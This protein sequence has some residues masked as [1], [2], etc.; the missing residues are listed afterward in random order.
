MTLVRPCLQEVYVAGIQTVSIYLLKP[1]IKSA[2]AAL[3]SE[4]NELREHAVS[5]GETTGTLFV[6]EGQ[7]G[8]PDWVRFLSGVTE[9]ELTDRTRSIKALLMLEAAGRW[10]AIT[11]G[12]ARHLLKPDSYE[13][14]F[15]L[16]CA[17]NGV[18]PERLRGAEA[19]TFDEHALHTLRQ[20]SHH[21]S[22]TSLEINTDR[23]LVVSLAGQLEDGELG[24]KVDGRDAVRLTADLEPSQLSQKCAELLRLSERTDYRDHF[25]FFDTIKRVRDPEEIARLNTKAFTALGKR[26]FDGFDLYPPQIVSDEIVTFRV[27]PVAGNLTVVEPEPTLLRYPLGVP[28]SP[29]KA[30]AKIRRF[31]LLGLDANREVVARWSFFDCLHWETADRGSVCVLDS[32]QWYRIDATLSKDVEAF[33]SGLGSSGIHWPLAKEKQTEKNYNDVAAK[34]DGLA[35]MDQRF[36]KLPGQTKIEACD[37][38]SDRRLFVHVKHRKGGSG[39]LSHLFAQAMVSAECFVTEP[40]FRKQLRQTLESARTGFGRFSPAQVNASDYGVVLA[41]ITS[42]TASGDVAE[43]LPFFSKVTLRL[44]VKRLTSMGFKVFVD[45]IRTDSGRQAMKPTPAERQ[46]KLRE[47]ASKASKDRPK[48]VSESLTDRR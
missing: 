11:F 15:G 29:S 2:R 47:R 8:P 39:P 44:A 31:H 48:L 16:L 23:E 19:R 32:G 43:K 33:A 35:L 26:S 45:Q 30:E 27:T 41:M 12:H 38:F 22:L 5:A 28:C 37:I 13:R 7:E 25:P 21:S 14:D 6:E 20:L 3:K 10:F 1:T 4:H 36:I 42:P 34:A 24:K 40:E 9:P 17:L 46:K 18:N